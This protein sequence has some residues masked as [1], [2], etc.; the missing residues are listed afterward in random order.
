V[1]ELWRAINNGLALPPSHEPSD[2]ADL[3]EY[4][5]AF[6]AGPDGIAP[7]VLLV[8]EL[9]HRVPEPLANE[10]RDWV[11]QVAQRQNQLDRI[12][13]RRAQ[14][15][16]SRAASGTSNPAGPGP[17]H[18]DHSSRPCLLIEITPD[19]IDIDEYIVRY[20]VQRTIDAWQPEPGEGAVRTPSQR[21]EW[22][23]ADAIEHAERLWRDSTD[24]VAIEFLLPAQ[25]LHLAVEWWRTELASAVPT[26][27]CVDYVVT[28]RSL[29]RMT[30][31]SRRRFW[32]SRWNALWREPPVHRLYWGAVEDGPDDLDAW[33][34]GLRDDIRVTTVVLDGSP[35]QH[36]GQLQ[37]ELAL[38]AGVPIVLWDRR[39]PLP[40]D[41]LATIGQL[42][43]GHPGELPER[44]RQLR[45][46]AAKAV[47]QAR[48]RHPGRH[49]A[50]LW[51]DP[52]RLIEV[53]GSGNGSDQLHQR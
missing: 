32:T 17:G 2:I 18:P 15:S 4:L 51:D 11:A 7:A 45:V 28:V 30:D 21:A 44:V 19:G 23:V 35:H 42:A 6:N 53:R 5:L 29:E 49:L 25:L 20:W 47:G 43:N 8:E 48:D 16:T 41:A 24:R 13:Q 52:G 46:A 33:D 12:Q 10:L 1:R 38:R 40:T 31:Y 14:R 34:A 37:L 26:P 50:L 27:L 9:A 36:R 39:G 3:Y 22:V